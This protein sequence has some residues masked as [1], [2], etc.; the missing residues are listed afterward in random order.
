MS[1][2]ENMDTTNTEG[3][4]D[5]AAEPEVQVEVRIA[6]KILMFTFAY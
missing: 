6:Q 3:A 1:S 5:T 4:G 2:E